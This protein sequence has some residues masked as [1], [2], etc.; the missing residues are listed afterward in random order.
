[1]H[2]MT[3]D[4][5]IP[6]LNSPTEGTKLINDQLHVPCVG[7]VPEMFG[8]RRNISGSSS[9]RPTAAAAAAAR[10]SFGNSL[11]KRLQTGSDGATGQALLFIGL[12]GEQETNPRCSKGFREQNRSTKQARDGI[13]EKQQSSS[14]PLLRHWSAPHPLNDNDTG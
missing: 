14:A 3:R 10:Q 8:R 12:R 5:K 13:P 4:C 6:L 7:F 1:M 2:R 11:I 9:Q